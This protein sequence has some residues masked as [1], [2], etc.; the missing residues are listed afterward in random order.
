MCGEPSRSNRIIGG[1]ESTAHAWPWMCSFQLRFSHADGY[2]YN[3]VCGCAI[4]NNDWVITAAHCVYV[5]MYLSLSL[6]VSVSLSVW[7][8]RL[9]TFYLF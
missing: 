9:K 1:T 4:V 7:L 5:Y 6:F 2:K 3:H 8:Q